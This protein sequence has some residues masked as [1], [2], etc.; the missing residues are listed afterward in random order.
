M[1]CQN[2]DCSRILLWVKIITMSRDNIPFTSPAVIGYWLF[3][4]RVLLSTSYTFS[5]SDPQ[6]HA[7][8]PP[9]HQLNI[10]HRLSFLSRITSAHKF[11]VVD[12]TIW[13]QK[14]GT[15][16][17]YSPKTSGRTPSTELRKRWHRRRGK[18]NFQFIFDSIY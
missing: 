9:R 17:F 5:T 12:A 14:G 4:C 18:H 15:R 11:Q 13:R 2:S 6:A 3:T 10:Y 8:T 7:P 16:C 1:S